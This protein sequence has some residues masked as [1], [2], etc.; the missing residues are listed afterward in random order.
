MTYR[1]KLQ[2]EHPD[3]VDERWL[4]GC[5]GCPGHYGYGPE[6]LSDCGSPD[7]SKCAECW[8]KAIP[9]KKEN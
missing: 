4:G 8:D 3:V 1:E 7:P 6:H 9:D 2:K 5:R